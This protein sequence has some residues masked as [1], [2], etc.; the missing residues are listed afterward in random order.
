MNKIMNESAAKVAG[1]YK[2]LTYY[3]QYGGSVVIVV[4]LIIILFLIYSY[5]KSNINSQPIRDNWPKYRCRP[6]VI[7]FAGMI[8]KPDGETSLGYT[9]KNFNYCLNEMVKPITLK[10]VNPI[11]YLMNGLMKVFSI[12]SRAIEYIRSLIA[13]MRT[14]MAKIV[15]NIFQRI[16]A[17]LI[18]IQE[19]MIRTKDLFGKSIAILK[20]G[21]ET[22]V[23]AY[24][25][26][27][28]SMGVF[29]TIGA[30]SLIIGAIV[31]VALFA[32]FIAA[33]LFFPWTLGY[34]L[35]MIASFTAAYLV[36][37]VFVLIIITFMESVM[38][39]RPNLQV[40]PPPKKPPPPATCFDPNTIITLVNGTQKK[41]KDVVVGD[42]LH[43]KGK[44]T[45]TFVLNSF[46][47]PMYNLSDIIVSGSH[48]VKIGD[49]WVCV[50]DHPDAIEL[51]DEYN[52]PYVYN[53]NTT[54]KKIIINGQTFCDWD[55]ISDDICLKL[56]SAITSDLN[57]D[58][59]KSILRRSD[60]SFIHKYFDGGFEDTS[61]V[62]M[63]NGTSKN[64]KEIKVSDM[65]STGGTVYGLVKIKRP[66]IYTSEHLDNPDATELYHLLV[67][68]NTNKFVVNNHKVF[69]YNN[70]IE[71]VI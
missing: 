40:A 19:M 66:D 50:K 24:V 21:L 36:I 37:M 60:K 4:I 55:E 54:T 8:N 31:L 64:I 47:Q 18:P 38:E 71:S 53:L 7:P 6:D 42:I 23:G 32:L 34:V 57:D 27:K 14:R 1:L 28:S 41:I 48:K 58:L 43:D 10:A 62:N 5:F 26:L 25:T 68:G 51:E 2:G 44:V 11:D 29:V 70:Y 52:E 17:M 3:D 61:N 63:V 16:L 59:K 13:K 56:I 30:W 67:H 15:K 65:L 20:V 35:F 39:V 46:T 22:A 9:Q 69:D 45:A 12:I 33:V 49:D